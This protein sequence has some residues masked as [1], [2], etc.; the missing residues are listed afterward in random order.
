M[1][2]LDKENMIGQMVYVPKEMPEI[3]YRQEILDGHPVSLIYNAMKK[4]MYHLKG[5]SSLIWSLI[6]GKR[7]IKMIARQ[8]AQI[9]G[10]TD[11]DF[12]VKDVVKCIVKAGRL[13]LIKF[14]YKIKDKE[15]QHVQK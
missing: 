2:A 8:V 11:E 4:E 10:E 15:I 12:L 13:G 9:T 6:D 3:L 5:N 14:A 1:V 7:T